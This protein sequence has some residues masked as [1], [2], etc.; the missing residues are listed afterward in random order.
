MSGSPDICTEAGQGVAIQE[1]ISTQGVRLSETATGCVGESGTVDT[2]AAA[3]NCAQVWTG[4]CSLKK[5]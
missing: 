5:Y 3:F 2:E 1:V 4:E